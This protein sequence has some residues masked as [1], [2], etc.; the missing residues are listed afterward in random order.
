MKYMLAKGE[1]SSTAVNA[2]TT[3]VEA[4]G[5]MVEM[6]KGEGAILQAAPEDI[7]DKANKIIVDLQELVRMLN[8]QISVSEPKATK[9]EKV[10]KKKK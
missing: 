8:E 4:L 3:A 6:L 7:K 2:L 10:V 9:K 1:S 5:S